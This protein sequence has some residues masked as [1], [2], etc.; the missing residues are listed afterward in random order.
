MSYLSLLVL[1]LAVITLTIAKNPTPKCPNGLNIY[2][3]PTTDP[4]KLVARPT[5]ESIITL[6]IARNPTPPNHQNLHKEVAAGSNGLIN[7]QSPTTDPQ[8]L[9]ALNC[10]GPT[11]ESM[12]LR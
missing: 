6:A 10:D 9:V 8:K 1:F 4:Q 12:F 2:Q 11:T 5:S 3:S 7:Y